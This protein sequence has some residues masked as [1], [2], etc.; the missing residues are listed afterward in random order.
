MAE[1]DRRI[2]EMQFENRQFEKNIAKSTKS[3]ED[4]K[5]AMDFE[6]VSSGLKKFA[7]GFKNIDLSRL[8]DNIQKLTD[9]FTG[10][11]TLSELVLSQIRRGIEKA[12]AQISSFV[13]S[14]TTAQVSAGMDKYE[15]LNKSVQTI[16]AATGRDEKEVYGVLKRL[17]EYTDQTS[18][19]FSDMAQNIGKFTSVGINLEDAEK[20]MEGIANWAARSGAG[21]NEASRAMYNLSQAMG[22]GKLTKIDWKSIENAGMATKEFKEQ[23][24][25][26]GLAAG[27]L[28]E[29]KGVIKT[30]KTLG[31]QMEVTYKNLA[32]TLSKGWA[33]S[34]V[35]GKTLQS[36]YYEDL[37]YENKE[38]VEAL[39]KLL[40]QVISADSKLDETGWK[41]MT[42][43]GL[44]T[45]EFKQQLIDAGVAQ[46]TLTKEVKKDGTVIY[47]TSSKIGKSVAVTLDNIE[48][49]LSSGW[50]NK[51]VA[52]TVKSMT[53][54][55]KASYESAQKCLTFTDVINAWKDQISTGWMKSYSIIFGELS[56]SMEF[57]SDVCNRVGDAIGNLIDLRNRVLQ[58]WSDS[59]GRNS[60]IELIL[61]DPETGAVGFLDLLE[62]AKDMIF[63]GFKDFMMLFGSDLDKAAVESNPEYF[64][65]YLGY[66]LSDAMKGVQDFMKGIND[67]FNGEVEYDGKVK[68]RL[69]LIHDVVDGIAGALKIGYDI[70]S[71]A[72]TFLGMIGE[73]LTPGLDALLEF[74]AEL[75]RSIFDTADEVG[76]EN[77]VKKF[78]EDL[79]ETVK[80]LTDSVN[81]LLVSISD[82]LYAIFG[83]DKEGKTQTENLSKI[84][85]AVK[86]VINFIV[87]FASPVIDFFSKVVDL[88]TELVKT[89]VNGESLKKFGEGL[90][91]A[92]GEMMTSWADALPDSLGF[93]KDWVHSLF[94]GAKDEVKSETD[95]LLSMITGTNNA[96]KKTEKD[97]QKSANNGPGLLGLMTG[98]NIAVWLTV[99]SLASVVMLLRKARKVVGSVGDFIGGLGD[100]LKN[101]LKVKYEDESFAKKF[102]RI[103]IAIAL[104]A[105]SIYVLG[106]MPLPGL[107]QGGIAVA[108]VCGV[109]FGMFKL[110]QKTSKTGGFKDQLAFAAQVTAL[111]FAMIALSVA[112]GIL[113]LALIPF[114]LMSWEQYAK[115][116]AGLGGILL[117]MV[118]FMWLVK[119][120]KVGDV[121]LAGFAGFA[122]GIGMI[123][124]GIAPFASMDIDQI[125][126]ALFGLG[127]I[128]LELLAFMMI[129]R[130]NDI[131]TKGIKLA[132]I[133]GFALGIAIL[134]LAVRSFAFMSLDQILLALV[135]L[136]G[137]LFELIAFMTYLRQ[138]DIGTKGIKLAGIIAFALGITI[139]ILA[140]RS[141][142][143]MSLDQIANALFGLG[144][145]LLELLAFMLILKRNDV[146]NSATFLI[147]YILF[148][149][150]IKLL[151][152]TIIPLANY[153][154]DKIV[155]MLVGLGGV[156][157]ELLF[158]MQI[159]KQTDA[160]SAD[161]VGLMG[162]AYGLSALVT[163]ILPFADM[164]W[165]DY[166]KTMAG[167]A[168]A[169]AI[170]IGFMALMKL[171]KPNI[172]NM[173]KMAVFC[174][175]LAAVAGIFAVIL[176]LV[177]DIDW[178]VIAAF[179]VGLTALVVGMSIASAIAA[180]IGLKGF[181]IL[182][183]GLVLIFGALALVLPLLI[184]SVMGA[185]RNA[186][187]D[188]TI[189]SDLMKDVSNNMN[190]V[191]EGGF[192]K[193]ERL[194]GMIGDL[195]LLISKF[196]FKAGSTSV[197]MTA[198]AALVLAS[199]EMIKFDKKMISLSDD[200][201][202]SKAIRLIGMYKSIFEDN[203]TDFEVYQTYANSFF[204]SVFLLGAAFDYFENETKDL[205]DPETNNGLKLIKELAGCAKDLDIIYKMDLDHFKDQLAELGGA[206]IVY[207]Q[208][209]E[210]VNGGEIDDSTDVGG[211]VLLLHK[212]A[213]AFKEDGGFE[214]PTNMPDD[215]S[216]TEFGVQ[217]AALAGALVAFE[218]AGKGLGD[219]TDKALETLTFFEE[220]KARLETMNLGM[221]VSSAIQS[222]KDE[223]G[224]LIEQD[225]LTT[226]GEDIAKLGS[227]MKS[228]AA[229]TQLT[230]EETGE[231]KPIDFTKATDALDAIASLN[232]KLPSFGGLKEVIEGRQKT[233]TDL[234]TDIELLG[235]AMSEFYQSTTSVNNS[236][237]I[238]QPLDFSKATKFLN[239]IVSMQTELAKIKI[240]GLPDFF[241]GHEMS[242]GDLSSQLVQ[243]GSGLNQ[244]SKKIT[245]GGT[246]DEGNAIEPFDPVSAQSA[247]DLINDH[248]VPLMESL[249]TK[250][251]H[252]GGLWDGLKKL[253]I[254]RNFDLTDLSTQLGKIGEGLGTLGENL[255]KGN[256]TNNEGA[257]NAFETLDSVIN[258][259]V[260]LQN[261]YN[262]MRELG[263]S[264]VNADS[265]FLNLVEFMSYINDLNFHNKDGMTLIE[266]IATFMKRLDTEL[267][268]W[269]DENDD[270]MT[271]VLNR[272]E[273]FKLFTEGM[274]ALTNSNLTSDWKFIGTKL[275]SDVAQSLLDGMDNVTGALTTLFQTVYTN[276]TSIE[277]VDWEKLGKNIG[278]GIKAGVDYASPQW[279]TPAVKDMMIRAYNA[280]KEAI[281]SNSPSKLFMELGEFM[282]EGTAIGLKDSTDDV[283]KNASLM[284]KVALEKARDMIALISTV[285]A[286]DIS[287]NPTI[288]PILDM[289]NMEAGMAD[290]RRSLNG[291]G[292]NLNAS[293]SASRALL[294][295]AAQSAEPYSRP[296]YSGIYDRMD[297]LGEKI[298]GMEN[299][300]KH[301]KLVLDTGVVAGGV[302]DLVDERIGQKIWLLDRNN[303]V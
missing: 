229:S 48:S 256:W 300:I 137:I 277:G 5:K 212:I 184:G 254:G 55:A 296:D 238:A 58:A 140:V 195:V 268:G 126:N 196:A 59:G 113:A 93:I 267:T 258:M 21:I 219:G 206:M 65:T 250:L 211:A 103:G 37:Y 54:L 132:G 286:E 291:Y 53:S 179:T 30:A 107:I 275:T 14:M 69:E 145:I 4:L 189:I 216:I 293:V 49:T 246:D 231:I 262:R 82:L 289:T 101:G 257:K 147:G 218:E 32:E 72:I 183:A 153:S 112:V 91:D 290:F 28:V 159:M 155:S 199:D 192:E 265:A 149:I 124:Q 232:E 13:S 24:I 11:G 167:L 185:L 292:V 10:L 67:F 39:E 234:A 222:F 74:F 186:A 116:M 26:A 223:N 75:G 198:M 2:I 108:V 247:L 244:F 141:F 171:V 73:D 89:G 57:F 56:E 303:T 288:T 242:F 50:F 266:Q 19:N 95:S 25:Q 43:T 204:S 100:T 294:T 240:G 221:S 215:K 156:L 90:G 44:A 128:L 170:M 34:D 251:P 119:K 255:N 45:K 233:L 213:E 158:F 297:Q 162:F 125:A 276:S 136:G 123:V 144:G 249:K 120:A 161:V 182:A 86:T 248:V 51:G 70:I 253:V 208:G 260:D 243:L 214:I 285:M 178:K 245:T 264:G 152:D 241:E 77:K 164:D 111:A 138:N 210:K 270:S 181:A 168:G 202:T 117:E 269:A 115:A 187:G 263:A 284:G 9:K 166:A 172:S 287:S 79:R 279:V 143:F 193:A 15:M 38:Q 92:F 20:Q 94:G 194:I 76:K 197:F 217:I 282:G 29:E 87:K 96:A 148:A 97:A 239:S 150:G 3:V 220:L 142:A 272:L 274:N 35:L 18:Y 81:N 84:G 177:K 109:M 188:L 165:E 139:L 134:I 235:S 173:L 135:G 33:T 129:M 259:M 224:K 200:G 133:I 273:A 191:D 88:I 40:D 227:A 1:K 66:K 118:A 68:T 190:G 203:L 301:M 106:S 52:Q 46:G 207:A 130:E 16:K 7:E 61:G 41:Q 225:E 169:L 298:I 31:K 71:G 42:E 131:G 110:L 299:S 281:D 174:G 6:Q 64:A 78:F 280:G 105:A 83:L 271:K 85:N 102:Q 146:G 209:A 60:M 160:K 151:I 12:A 176:G 236:E 226:F 127:G 201:G 63:D 237:G 180:V 121:Q 163:A 302:S 228:F 36:Y 22:M 23:L 205:K 230:D 99:A 80:P 175:L 27:T 154:I 283:G 122:L 104:V 8:T 295:G 62:G 252:V 114:T 98:S 278:L 17:N 47:K 261:F 157:I